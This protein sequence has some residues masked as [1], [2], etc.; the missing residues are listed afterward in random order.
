[1]SIRLRPYQEEAK[2]VACQSL[3]GHNAF[4]L[5]HTIGSGK[6]ITALSIAKEMN[7]PVLVVVP[8]ALIYQWCNEAKKLGMELTPYV[9]GPATRKKLLSQDLGLV[10]SYNVFRNDFQDIFKL[11][12][13]MPPY[14]LI[15][16]EAQICKNIRAKTHKYVRKLMRFTYARLLMLS[17]TIITEPIDSYGICKIL[18]P[19]AWQNKLHFYAEHVAKEDFFG[20][21]LEYKNLDKLHE[22][23]YQYSHRAGD[24]VLS[25]D[26]PV[27]IERPYA[28]TP[29]HKKMYDQILED[30]LL[31]LDDDTLISFNDQLFHLSQQLIVAPESQDLPIKN[32]PLYEMLDE[33]FTE[34]DEKFVLFTRY[35]AHTEALAEHYNAVKFYGQQSTQENQD[36]KDLFINDPDVRFLVLNISAGGVGLDGLQLICSHCVFVD[37]P[38]TPP[39]FSQA[40]GRLRRSGQ[41]RPVKVFLPYAMGTIQEELLNRVMKRVELL[42]KVNKDQLREI[43][44]LT[45]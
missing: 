38:L 20:N 33:I 10:M 9:G 17:G 43:L 12:K 7:M 41:L 24:E 37:I 27:L 11:L 29:K 45:R 21:I 25:Q 14:L 31:E 22:K 15:L 26:K 30:Q 35:V 3:E 5:D 1:M 34:A 2:A 40:I 42:S 39:E 44:R 8:A 36:A 18:S 6:T 23:L 32:K 16:D 13:K 19:G 28:L 4:L